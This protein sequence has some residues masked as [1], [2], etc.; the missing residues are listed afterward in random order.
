MTTE[1]SPWKAFVAIGIL[2]L[3]LVSAAVYQ[4]WKNQRV[5]AQNR[6]NGFD[7]AEAQG[8]LW[9]TRIQVGSQPYDIPFYHHPRELEGIV[10]RDHDADDLLT[11]ANRTVRQVYLSVDPDA[12]A[13][14]AAIAGVEI[15]RIAGSKYDLLNLP[16]TGALTR[17]ANV[18]VEYP[19]LTCEDATNETVV[20]QLAPDP[21]AN[22]IVRNGNCVILFY[23]NADDA[24]RVADRYAYM[25]LGIMP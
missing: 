21:T 11:R 13:K 10:V 17:P 7:F 5:I 25:L 22:A 20:I 18:T 6:Y 9:V 12:G 8:G 2:A 23:R 15:A 19:I 14:V 4:S 24:I 3:L 16:T 1:A